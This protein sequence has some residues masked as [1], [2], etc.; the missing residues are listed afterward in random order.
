M[1][2]IPTIVDSDLNITINKR[3]HGTFEVSIYYAGMPIK[4]YTLGDL[5]SILLSCILA[6]VPIL[7]FWLFSKIRRKEMISNAYAA[8]I[9]QLISRIKMDVA[10]AIFTGE[11][12]A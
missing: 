10:E 6:N 5:A 4:R 9:T 2:Q 3:Y 1:E 12:N 8:A 7:G 11:S